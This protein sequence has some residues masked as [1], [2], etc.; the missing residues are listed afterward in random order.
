MLDRDVYLE[1]DNFG[2]EFTS[3]SAYGRF[4]SDAERME[5]L[6]RLIAEG[7][8]GRRRLALVRSDSLSVRRAESRAVD[9]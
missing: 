7:Y 8:A 3:G 4:P 1:F 6:Y 5:A 9:K 2:K